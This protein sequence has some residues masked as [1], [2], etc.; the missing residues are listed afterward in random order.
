VAARLERVAVAI[1]TKSRLPIDDPGRMASRRSARWKKPTH[2]AASRVT[3]CNQKDLED[4]L[5]AHYIK[6]GLK[7]SVL[8]RADPMGML[9]KGN[10]PY[11]IMG[12]P[13]R[14][15]GRTAD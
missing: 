9:F 1:F 15:A 10:P 13:N 14:V 5:R 2:L 4:Q 11:E 8:V 6:L 12:K 7:E 3:G